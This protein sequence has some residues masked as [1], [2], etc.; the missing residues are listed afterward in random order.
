MFGEA[1]VLA[2]AHTLC[3][4]S[5]ITVDHSGVPVVYHHILFDR[6]QIIMANGLPTE[7]FFPG[8]SAMNALDQAAQA[9]IEALFPDLPQ[10]G[11]EA[12][13]RPVLKAYEARALVAST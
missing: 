12:S 3:N 13:A 9:E 10:E 2:P 4:E 7:S 8:A 1:E 6:H 5:S 11:F